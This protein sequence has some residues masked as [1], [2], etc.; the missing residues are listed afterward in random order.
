MPLRRIC[1][2]YYLSLHE[3]EFVTYTNKVPCH[4]VVILEELIENSCI[5]SEI[6]QDT[7]LL[8]SYNKHLNYSHSLSMVTTYLEFSFA[9]NS[10]TL[11]NF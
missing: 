8:R 7:Q 4:I 5:D 3:L 1:S 2:A 9:T 11:E 10:W 6:Y